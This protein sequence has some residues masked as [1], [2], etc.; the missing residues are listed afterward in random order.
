MTVAHQAPA[1]SHV[2]HT[3]SSR[4]YDNVASFED[5]PDDDLFADDS[6]PPAHGNRHFS[7]SSK[8][9]PSSDG[10]ATAKVKRP[11]FS[12]LVST[13]LKT[14][15]SLHAGDINDNGERPATDPLESSTTTTPLAPSSG[16]HLASQPAFAEK[17]T[18]SSPAFKR[19][20]LS[21]EGH[22]LNY[23]SIFQK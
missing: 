5:L 21:K 15:S 8:G 3:T 10:T 16:N 6:K 22:E 14:L 19:A 13:P 12:S 11:A 23:K 1:T 4:A 20:L 9:T 7:G 18:S 2:H 17:N